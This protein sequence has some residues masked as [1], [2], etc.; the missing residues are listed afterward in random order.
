MIIMNWWQTSIHILILFLLAMVPST[1]FIG[2]VFGQAFEW[3][4]PTRI[5]C[6]V[7][8]AAWLS[9]DILWSGPGFP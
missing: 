5:V 2:Y 9:T 1:I 3:K 8:V 4:M 6:T 7:L